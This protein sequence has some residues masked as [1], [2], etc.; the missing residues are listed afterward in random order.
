VNLPGKLNAAISHWMT[1][2]GRGSLASVSRELS[3]AYRKG[4]NSSNVNLAAYLTTRVPATF[5]A[6]ETVQHALQK[7]LPDFAPISLLDI[8][9]GPGVASWAALDVWT[10]IAK[11]T[12]CEQDKNFA[13]L[14]AS[15]NAASEVA[16]MSAAEIILKSEA[17]LSADVKAD[18]V[19]A[20]YVLAEL[21]LQHMPQTA[22][23]LWARTSH[24]LLLIEPGTP[25]GFARLRAVRETLLG[26][27][28]FVLAPCTHQNACPMSATDWCHF[29]TRVQRSREHMHAK[30]GTVPF[31][32][33]AYSYL[34]L[35]RQPALQMG[36]RIIAPVLASKHDLTLNLCDAAGLRNEVIASRDKP[37]YKRAKKTAW[38]HVWE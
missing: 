3:M 35:S 15:L 22:I 7:A 28:A 33:E 2:H 1:E 24:V 26:Q 10:S 21:P 38:G 29:K 9:A 25:Q 13:S 11:I 14:A 16:A 12:L 8:G 18:L 34:I 37:S 23:R 32:D 20:S 5:A 19:M 4:D 30:G 6:N 36:A 27:G 31:E 17:T